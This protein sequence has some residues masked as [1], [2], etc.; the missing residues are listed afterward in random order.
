MKQ[1]VKVI[2]EVIFE[3]SIKIQTREPEAPSYDIKF[4]QQYFDFHV[5]WN[6]GVKQLTKVAATHIDTNNKTV[7]SR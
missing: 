3:P 5:A 7:K 2:E 6:A 4:K 1:E